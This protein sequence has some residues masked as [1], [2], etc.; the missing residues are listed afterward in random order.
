MPVKLQP[1]TVIDAALAEARQRLRAASSTRRAYEV[2]EHAKSTEHS[3]PTL[4]CN[5]EAKQE[6]IEPY[7][8]II[9]PA[10][11]FLEYGSGINLAAYACRLWPYDCAPPKPDTHDRPSSKQTGAPNLILCHRHR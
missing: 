9:T 2:L 1:P 10:T 7:I 11:R 8:V 3:W 4:R 5:T 6:I